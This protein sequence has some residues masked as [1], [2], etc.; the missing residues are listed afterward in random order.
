VLASFQVQQNNQEIRVV[1]QDGSVYNGYWQSGDTTIRNQ[2]ANAQ[3]TPAA[4]AV[5]PA[6]FRDADAREKK[7]RQQAAM[8]CSFRVAGMNQS[9]KQNVVFS[10]NL[11]AITS[12][13]PLVQTNNLIFAVSGEAGGVIQNATSNQS[14]QLLLSNSRI[15]GTAVID[16]TKQ[17]EI[18]AVPSSP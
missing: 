13:V 11:T 15:S 14:L 6:R 18:N 5:P 2:A 10:G 12:G 1:D 8:S 7:D 17:I 4:Q 16:S 3:Q 9:L